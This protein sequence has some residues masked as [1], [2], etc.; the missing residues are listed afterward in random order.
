MAQFF[1]EN[2]TTLEPLSEYRHHTEA[3]IA[4]ALQ[5]AVAKAKE[6][7]QQS[8]DLKSIQMHNLA[9]Q[10]RE[11][12]ENLAL[13]MALE[14]GKPVSQGRSEVEKC[15]LTCEHYADRLEELIATE[16]ITFEG[17]EHR[18]L[19]EPLGLVLAVMPW[20]FPLWQV[21]RS[22][23]PILVA[24]NGYILKHSEIVAGTAELLQKITDQVFGPHLVTNL[25]LDHD[26]VAKLIAD[27]QIKAV[28]LTGSSKAG[29]IVAQAAGKHLKKC[30]LELGGSDPVLV[31]ED[32]DL[33]M[34]I[35]LSVKSRLI[36]AGQSCISAKRFLIPQKLWD[37]FVSGMSEKM[38]QAVVGPPHE[39][40]TEIGPLA[41]RRFAEQCRTQLQKIRSEGAKTL[42][43]KETRDLRGAFV[44][45][46]ML[47]ASPKQPSY[48]TEEFFSPVAL[49]TPYSSI[50]EGIH[51]A[52]ATAYGLGSTIVTGNP[53]T[54][55]ALA[56]LLDCGVVAVNRI[57]A[58]DPRLP[59]GGIKD[60]GYGRELSHFG[61]TEFQNIKTLML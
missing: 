42:W 28:T 32:A 46:A 44:V 13:T 22:M 51:L 34:A 55:E 43:Q 60:S 54:A 19:R 23:V 9:V 8:I 48:L 7:R 35:D 10:L 45:P 56:P 25:F 17:R 24:G 29:S 50:E 12:Q 57:L 20:N 5:K 1:T 15:A 38:D 36:N 37:N 26:Q 33:Q 59:F 27:R 18:I 11:Q 3:E 40:K 47:E 21:I 4:V 31:L 6:W 14:M 52:N 58:S 49:L 61:V 16:T 41:H 30:V 39:D 2:P 53:T